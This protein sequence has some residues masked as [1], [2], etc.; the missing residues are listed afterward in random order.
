MVCA[1]SGGFSAS[2]PTLEF[3]EQFSSPNLLQSCLKA[4]KL[5]VY[6]PFN[7]TTKCIGAAFEVKAVPK[8]RLSIFADVHKMLLEHQDED[9]KSELF[10]KGDCGH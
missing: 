2:R 5:V 3:P 4:L 10:N 6:D 1:A 9:N 8:L 7:M